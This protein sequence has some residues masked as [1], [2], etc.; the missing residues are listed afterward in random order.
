MLLYCARVTERYAERGVAGVP[1][2]FRAIGNGCFDG[3][4]PGR[5]GRAGHG[6]GRAP[7]SGPAAALPPPSPPRTPRRLLRVAEVAARPSGRQAG[8][9]GVAQR[10]ADDVVTPLYLC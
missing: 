10:R 6:R 9:S 5:A 7:G 2:E 4:A 1:G 8:W 3:E